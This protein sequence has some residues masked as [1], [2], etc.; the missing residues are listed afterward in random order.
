MAALVIRPQPRQELFLASPADIA[1]F[2]GAGGGGK[3]WALTYEGTRHS[4]NAG[5][6]AVY[7]RR[8]TPEL[9]K[10]GGL[11]D[12]A[13][14][15]YRPLG[16]LLLP[17]SSEGRVA[18]FPS[19]AR[20]LFSHLESDDTLE[21]W[22]GAQVPLIA[23]DEINTFTRL[24]FFYM[25][26]RN[27]SLCG[28]RPYV[29]GSCNPDADSWLAEF[30]SWWIC[31][32]SGFPIS[33]GFWDLVAPKYRGIERSGKLRYFARINDVLH[34]ADTAQELQDKHPGVQ[35]KSVTFVPSKLS[36]NAVLEKADPGYRANLMALDP[37]NRARLLDGNWKI[38]AAAGLLFQ[39]GWCA[40]VDVVPSDLEVVSYWDLAGTKKTQSNDPDF[41]VRIKLAR[42]AVGA[43]YRY[44]VLDMTEA[45]ED[46]GEVRTLIRNVASADGVSVRIRVPQDPGQAGKD[47]SRDIVASM[48][49]YDISSRIET[50]D[51][52]T[53]FGPF[54]AQ[55]KAGNVIFKRGS[56]NERLWSQ[57][58]GFPDARHKDHA[59]ACSGAFQMFQDPTGGWLEFM[60]LQA[61]GI[62]RG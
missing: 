18:R 33:A 59:D 2:G 21:D 41:T 31:E 11:W 39:R 55:C 10:P 5:F 4:R 16:A 32:E 37:I 45:Q 40:V 23:F 35:P 62:G 30:L 54:S 22:K 52:V 14:K 34:W 17:Q 38:R 36:D 61:Q 60:R 15:L 28:V 20:C 7:F 51:K 12:E 19:G 24:M 46:P 42:Q 50:G 25:L 53:R 8:T 6:S 13:K 58:E 56:W 43:G 3:S 29:R 49:G 1:I 9:M 57:L 44:F 27:R 48:G 26:S 47:Q